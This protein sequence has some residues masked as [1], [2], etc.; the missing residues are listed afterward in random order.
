MDLGLQFAAKE[1]ETG[2]RVGMRVGVG[3]GGP[4]GPEVQRR[5]DWLAE[6]VKGQRTLRRCSSDL[7]C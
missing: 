6:E 1:E 7:Q 2:D 4:E 5:S 3:V